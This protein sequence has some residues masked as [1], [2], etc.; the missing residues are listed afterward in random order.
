MRKVYQA[1]SQIMAEILATQP[2]MV[3]PET[4]LLS[5]R[6]QELAAAVIGCEKTFHIRM[7]DERIRELSTVAAWV[8]Y[9]KE[10]IAEQKEDASPADEK[11]R[12]SWYYR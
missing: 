2:E 12:D 6:Y 11:E 10:R 7:E 5:L 1:V 3:S 4:S 8:E 9:V